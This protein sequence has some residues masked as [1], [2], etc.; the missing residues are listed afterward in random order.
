MFRKFEF[1]NLTINPAYIDGEMDPEDSSS[2][3]DERKSFYESLDDNESPELSMFEIIS[4][5]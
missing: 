4:E 1:K 5:I 3:S 2:V